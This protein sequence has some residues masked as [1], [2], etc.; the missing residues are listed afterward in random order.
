MDTFRTP[1]SLPF[2]KMSPGA[3]LVTLSAAYSKHAPLLSIS[4]DLSLLI[5]KKHEGVLLFTLC[6]KSLLRISFQVVGCHTSEH[7]IAVLWSLF[8]LVFER[9]EP[10]V[11]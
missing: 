3:E 11:G 4:G 8:Q 5:D 9:V 1:L 6:D 10:S 7:D 2:A